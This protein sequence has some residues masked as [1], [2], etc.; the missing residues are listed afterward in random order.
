[1]VVA[2]CNYQQNLNKKKKA[3]NTYM[4]IHIHI[5]SILSKTKNIECAIR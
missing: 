1:M 5:Y 4:Y 3:K 2:I